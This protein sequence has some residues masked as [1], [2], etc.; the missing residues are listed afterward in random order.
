M[1]TDSVD[2]ETESVITDGEEDDEK[3]D[4]LNDLIN[5]IHYAFLNF[6]ELCDHYR[7]AL[8]R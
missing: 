5:K 8:E 6:K 4:D 3:A 2:L 7:K 1:D